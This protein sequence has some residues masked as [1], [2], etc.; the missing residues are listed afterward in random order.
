MT[1]DDVYRSILHRQK[2]SKEY[3]FSKSDELIDNHQEAP[4]SQP[5]PTTSRTITRECKFKQFLVP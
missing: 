2:G 3:I 1:F 5:K 4:F